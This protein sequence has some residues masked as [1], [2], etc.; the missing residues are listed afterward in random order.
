MVTPNNRTFH[1]RRGG[2]S[3]EASFFSKQ[4]MPK[5][6]VSCLSH[7]IKTRSTMVKAIQLTMDPP[8]KKTQ[9]VELDFGDRAPYGSVRL[10]GLSFLTN[11]A[12][13]R[14]KKNS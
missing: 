7:T 2:P 9:L 13:G 8:T 4:A 5:H 12:D 3:R 10:I 6:V 11:P 1:E 14:K